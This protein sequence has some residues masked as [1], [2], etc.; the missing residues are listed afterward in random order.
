MHYLYG[1]WFVLS[2]STAFLGQ[3]SDTTMSGIFQRARIFIF[4][5]RQ[6]E[7]T[8]QKIRIEYVIKNIAFMFILNSKEECMKTSIFHIFGLCPNL[9]GRGAV[10]ASSPVGV[11]AAL[12]VLFLRIPLG[13]VFLTLSSNLEFR[14][15]AMLRDVE[16][17]QF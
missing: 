7:M 16:A 3:G 5:G 13:F 2:K 11:F 4:M 17:S 6:E 15:A 10:F 9:R 1:R 14:Y 12:F 8:F